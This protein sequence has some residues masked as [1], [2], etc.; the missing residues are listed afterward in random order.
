MSN[1]EEVI[2]EGKTS[3]CTEHWDRDSKRLIRAVKKIGY[4]RLRERKSAEPKEA[5]KAVRVYATL[6]YQVGIVHL[7]HRN[8]R[9]EEFHTTAKAENLRKSLIRV[10][11][12]K[13]LVWDLYRTEEDGRRTRLPIGMQIFEAEFLLIIRGRK[14]TPNTPGSSK[15]KHYEMANQKKGRRNF[16]RAPPQES[17]VRPKVE[18]PRSPGWKPLAITPQAIRTEEEVRRIASQRL[19]E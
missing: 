2:V 6:E 5:P 1:S 12:L 13:N 11:R 19:K 17:I 15:R 9:R 16:V 3:E 8:R 7:A 18:P 4:D 14:K 10:F